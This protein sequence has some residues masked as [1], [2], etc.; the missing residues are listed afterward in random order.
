ME[1][2]SSPPLNM[3]KTF[4]A[5]KNKRLQLSPTPR[6]VKT[7]VPLSTDRI[8]PATSG[9]QLPSTSS[10]P[11]TLSCSNTE[12]GQ[13]GLVAALGELTNTLYEVVK[14]LDKQESRMESIEQK[15]LSPSS[16]SNTSSCES[17]KQKRTVPLVVRVSSGSFFIAVSGEFP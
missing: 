8:N 5:A 6:A 7:S 16:S 15:L 4:F 3:M 2:R 9:R 1:Q 17:C 11:K 10:T 12:S 13:V 14:R